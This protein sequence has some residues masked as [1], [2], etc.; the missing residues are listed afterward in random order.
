[1]LT[2]RDICSELGLAYDGAR[3]GKKWRDLLRERASK[4]E[5]T[6]KNPWVWTSSDPELM[7]VRTLL[8][9]GQKASSGYSQSAEY[10]A[11]RTALKHSAPLAPLPV[12]LE[13]G[14]LVPVREEGEPS[15]RKRWH[16]VESEQ[17]QE[18]VNEGG[19]GGEA[20]AEAPEEGDEM[21]ERADERQEADRPDA[22]LPTDAPESINFS[23]AE[24][25]PAKPDPPPAVKRKRTAS[26]PPRR[27][28]KAAGV[29][30]ELVGRRLKVWWEG[31][32]RWYKGLVMAYDEADGAHTVAY[33]DGDERTEELPRYEV[34]ETLARLQHKAEG[35][36][37]QW[38]ARSQSGYAGVDVRQGMA[39]PY[40]A[41][42][43]GGGRRRAS[44]GTFG[45]SIEAAV[46]FARACA[47]H[48]QGSTA[49]PRVDEPPQKRAKPHRPSLA[50]ASA[51]APPA[52]APPAA[53]SPQPQPVSDTLP[54][55]LLPA[56]PPAPPDFGAVSPSQPSALPV[57]PTLPAP[58]TSLLSTPLH[59]IDASGVHDL[60][61]RLLLQKRLNELA[62]E[63]AER[64]CELASGNKLQEQGPSETLVPSC[65]RQA[66]VSDRVLMC[67]VVRLMP[68][69][70][71]V[72]EK[73]VPCSVRPHV[74]EKWQLKLPLQRSG[75]L[76]SVLGG[77]AGRRDVVCQ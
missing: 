53:A 71:V 12:P 34:D 35:L 29:G 8:S 15:S 33:E 31:D 28:P 5:I 40:E 76:G 69:T 46:A 66:T 1:M 60:Q 43:E 52:A 24:L 42:I 63:I 65:D 19:E 23:F 48:S 25:V 73:D 74:R 64:M 16:A 67:V 75:A 36:R 6:A 47:A 49:L 32:G 70:H 30:A 38:D 72:R 37:L 77:G 59:E 58:T 56:L 20:E 41:R 57:L 44:L 13:L 55:A 39:K 62:G 2:L 26:T 61:Q 11:Y 50:A 3:P 18:G 14:S 9:S 10:K 4:G 68:L 27:V 54:L 51:V 22:V 45:T 21:E 7:L 17:G